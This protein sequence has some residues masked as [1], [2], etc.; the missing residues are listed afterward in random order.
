MPSART[1][2]S[3]LWPICNYFLRKIVSARVVLIR[4]RILKPNG[5]LGVDF[6]ANSARFC[7]STVAQYHAGNSHVWAMVFQ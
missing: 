3:P 5:V 2:A 6:V 1:T 7:P 4:P